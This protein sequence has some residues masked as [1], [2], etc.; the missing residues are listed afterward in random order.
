M[1]IDKALMILTV[2]ALFA[3]GCSDK[4]N[5]SEKI[6]KEMTE[7][8]A[9]TTTV[10]TAVPVV[11]TGMMADE[12]ELA[13]EAAPDM[14]RAPQGDGYTVQVSSATDESYAFYLVD[15][16]TQRGYEPYVTTITYNDETHFR[17]R[18]GLFESY[19]KAKKLVAG[20]EDKFSA[21]AWI[22]QVSN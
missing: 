16:W 19:S 8:T 17:V 21:E 6:E 4:K 9:E 1:K 11:D 22:D 3:S 20:L 10:D 2:A 15:L 14:P 5:D 12:P 13:D 18:I 7:L